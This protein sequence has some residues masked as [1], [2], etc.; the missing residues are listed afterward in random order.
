MQSW[1]FTTTVSSYIYKDTTVTF[2]PSI[3][4][5]NIPTGH[6][7]VRFINHANSIPQLETALSAA[8]Y[9]FTQA[10]EQEN[11]DIIGLPVEVS[12]EDFSSDPS[13]LCKVEIVYTDTIGSL[14]NYPRMRSLINGVSYPVLIPMALSNQSRYTDKNVAM[15]I[16]LPS[17]VQYHCSLDPCPVDK[18]DA[19]TILL[20]A[21]IKG[22]GVQ[23]TF[24]T[25]TFSVGI[26][27][28]GV[29]YLNIFDILVY[30][31]SSGNTLPLASI[32]D[33][34][35][36]HSFFSGKT[37]YANGFISRTNTTPVPIHLHNDQ[38]YFPNT[39]LSEL[40]TNY[41]SSDI[42]TED[43]LENG[44]YDLLD[45]FIPPYI[46]IREITP[47]SM[48]LLR[49]LGWY[50]DCPVGN[51]SYHTLA[52]SIMSC[53]STIYAPLSTCSVYISGNGV[54]LSN[55]VCELNTHDSSYTLLEAGYNRSFTIP[56][57]PNNIQWR[58]NPITKNIV[59]QIRAT[60]F[61]L[62]EDYEEQTKICEIEIPYRPNKPIIQRN[63]TSNTD[64]IQLH[65]SAF[66]NGS[67]FYTV[68]YT[69]LANSDVHT[70]STTA[71]AIDTIL[72]MPA[73]QYYDVEVYGTNNV[74]NSDSYCF[75]AGYSIEPEI[76]LYTQVI[77]NTLRYSFVF[78]NPDLE[79]PIK[80]GLVT[81]MNV[82]GSIVMSNRAKPGDY[83]NISSLARGYYTLVVHANG[84][85]YSKLFYK[86]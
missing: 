78:A 10:M 69:G 55:I 53:N 21:L 64:S 34:V 80:T 58:R 48:S 35:S 19:I 18:N 29:R 9:I 44:M 74:G 17:N 28:E 1:S 5:S 51:E 4:S 26:E 85:T 3:T 73:T 15:H 8:S 25:H 7:R 40:T 27:D 16:K 49:A 71:D 36:A 11:I 14:D 24:D 22:C 23:S 86:R 20:R 83:I 47:Y 54:D 39:P 59:G 75:T 61:T 46:S 37:I 12:L 38:E 68:T 79:R 41:V 6:N 13:I 43:E 30:N 60:A 66:A 56:E 65:L 52:N 62:I 82:S 81:I 31:W 45:A 50:Y 70:F 77:G 42:Y 63:E 33:G 72:R 76:S 57:I 2:Q 67:D 32:A 84:Q